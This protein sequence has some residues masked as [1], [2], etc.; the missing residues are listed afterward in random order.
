MLLR[1]VVEAYGFDGEC[2]WWVNEK[3]GCAYGVEEEDGR[4]YGVDER[5]D[6]NA[7]AAYSVNK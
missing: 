6:C 5:A 2:E 1:R 4:E 7:V 3:G